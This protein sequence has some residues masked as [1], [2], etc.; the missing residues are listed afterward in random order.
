MDG[1]KETF[2]KFANKTLVYPKKLWVQ[3]LISFVF[4]CFTFLFLIYYTPFNI[5]ELG[6][7]RFLPSCIYA[8]ITSS[9]IFFTLLLAPVIKKSL[10]E[11]GR[12]TNLELLIMI[13]IT[14]PFISIGNWIYNSYSIYNHILVVK[15]NYLILL[16][17]LVY[18]PGILVA[19]LFD[20]ET[21][22]LV[23]VDLPFLEEKESLEQVSQDE[24]TVKIKNTEGRT[25][26]NT[27]VSKFLCAYSNQNY[28]DFLTLDNGEVKKELLRVPFGRLFEQFEDHPQI[29]RC[30]R[31]RIVNLCY[32]SGF[33][34]DDNKKLIRLKH[35]SEAIPVS[36]NYPIEDHFPVLNTDNPKPDIKKPSKP[37][38]NL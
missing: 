28:T 16:M 30:H 18:F 12:F 22:K 23:I 6:D 36:R 20:W 32:L 2:F 5:N 7:N 3:L 1:F 13:I 21:R 25:I 35:I 26:L 37:T 11:P 4:F 29:I 27:P 24:A 33:I 38:L 8:I 14:M 34:Q 17:D 10:L 9:V 19:N 31:T 15:L